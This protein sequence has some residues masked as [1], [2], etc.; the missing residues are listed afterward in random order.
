MSGGSRV[1]NLGSQRVAR[2]VVSCEATVSGDEVLFELAAV[3]LEREV[4]AAGRGAEE[5]VL[6]FGGG[7]TEDG[8]GVGLF[9]SW[10][11]GCVQVGWFPLKKYLGDSFVSN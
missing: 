2:A 5:A 9:V 1:V 10:C 11:N 7:G 4:E 6:R 8:D 3:A